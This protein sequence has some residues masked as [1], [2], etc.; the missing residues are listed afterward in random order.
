MLLM[1]FNQIKKKENE[2]VKEFDAR[3]D[4]L[5][6]QI[7]KDL[8]PPE[9]TILLLY[10]NAFEG[11]FGFILKEKMPENLAKAKEYTM[12]IEEHLISSKIEPF[13]FPHARENLRQRLQPTM[14][15]I[16]SHSWLK[17]LIK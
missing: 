4:N 16:Q 10:L 6:S 9:A 17:S 3:F 7:P 11:Q 2:T 14:Y 5:Y 8:C 12:Q 15:R 1:Q 13:Q